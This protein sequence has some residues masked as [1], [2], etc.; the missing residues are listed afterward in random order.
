MGAVLECVNVCKTYRG[1]SLENICMH[2]EQGYLAALIGTNGVG[3]TTLMRILAGLDCR[4]KGKVLLDGME[5][6]EHYEKV[7]RKIGIVSED[8][9]Y[10]MDKNVVENAVFYE[11]YFDDWSMAK[12]YEWLDRL[13]ISKGQP[14]CQFSRGMY[15]KFQLA[16]TLAREVE[17][18]LLDEPT[19]GFDP[20]F[21]RDFMK[22]IQE[23]RDSNIG[24][25]MSTHIL[26]DIE[27]LADTVFVLR[28]GTLAVHCEESSM[29]EFL[30][31]NGGMKHD[32]L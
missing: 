21:R 12:Y 31:G 7:K 6:K 30:Q 19:A 20:V 18:L 13:E 24:I 8:I 27:H 25:L 22:M 2:L 16:V 5:M 32:A 11:K 26:S 29:E 23:I 17:F 9:S 1:F 4:Y 3:K 28:E 14:L 15:M 10:F